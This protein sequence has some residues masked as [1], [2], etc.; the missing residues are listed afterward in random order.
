MKILRRKLSKFGK[1]LTQQEIDEFRKR[2]AIFDNGKPHTKDYEYISS[3]L[4]SSNNDISYLEIKREH[5]L[6][7]KIDIY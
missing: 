5:L 4:M 6:L 3:G 2:P 1:L 7:G